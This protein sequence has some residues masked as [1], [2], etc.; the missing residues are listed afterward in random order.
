MD[1]EKTGEEFISYVDELIATSKPSSRLGRAQSSVKIKWHHNRIEAYV[2]R[3]DRLQGS[4]SLATVLSLRNRETGSHQ[5]VLDHLI[6]IE[7]G[8]STS[9]QNGDELIRALSLLHGL[10]QEQ[11]GPKLDMLQKQMDLCMEDI[12][13]IR[14]SVTV[15][16]EGEILRWLDFRQRTWRF[17]EVEEAHQ[18]TFD[19]IFRK[20]HTNTPW[21]D[22]GA[23][24]SEAGISKPY[25]INGKVGSGKSTLMKY[26]ISNRQTRVRLKEWAGQ[27]KLLSPY[28]FF[29]N[30]GTQLQKSHTGMLRS[31]LH[32]ILTQYH[33]LIPAVFP[34]LYA[35]GIPISDYEPPSYTELKGAFERLKVR[36]ASFLRICIFVDGVDEFEGDHRDMSTF[37]CS[38]ASSAIK[39]V[40]SSRPINACL[41][42]FKSC[43]T[44][45]L[46]DLTQDD[47]SIFIRD[48]L[49]THWM[50]AELRTES[51]RAVTLEAEIQEKAEGVF[52]WVRIVT[53]LLLRGLDDGDDLDDLLPKLRALPSDLRELYTRMMQ[54]MPPDYQ[55]QA[56]Q[57]FQIFEWWRLHH[58][59]DPLELLLLAFAIQQPST[60]L[61]FD[62]NAWDTQMKKRYSKR[63]KA[64]VRSRCCGLLEVRWI[65]RKSMFWPPTPIVAYL[66]RSVAEFVTS[67]DVWDELL[68]LTNN[69]MRFSPSTQIACGILS[70]L[71]SSH[72]TPDED[73]D[74]RGVEMSK[75]TNYSASILFL[76][77]S[78]YCESPDFEDSI[79]I[80]YME[81][82]DK[83][84]ASTW[85]GLALSSIVQQDHQHS[86][87]WSISLE[88]RCFRSGIDPLSNYAPLMGQA[89]IRSFAAYNGILP[90]L[91]ALDRSSK[92]TDIDALVLFA[93]HGW[94]DQKGS[95][96]GRWKTL[97]FLLRLLDDRT[98]LGVESPIGTNTLWEHAEVILYQVYR[99]P[100]PTSTV[101][102]KSWISSQNTSDDD[103]EEEE[104]EEEEKA[105]A[106]PDHRWGQD[107]NDDGQNCNN[108]NQELE[109]CNIHPESLDQKLLGLYQEEPGLYPGEL[110]LDLEDI[111]RALSVELHWIDECP[112]RDMIMV[113]EE[114]QREQER[115]SSERTKQNS[116]RNEGPNWRQGANQR[117]RFDVLPPTQ[118]QHSSSSSLFSKNIYNTSYM[119]SWLK[120]HS[121]CVD[122]LR[123]FLSNTDK[124]KE[125]LDMSIQIPDGST[126]DL[127]AMLRD[128]ITCEPRKAE[129]RG[130]YQ[131]VGLPETEQ[132]TGQYIYSLTSRKACPSHPYSSL[133]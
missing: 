113:M 132:S 58:E 75:Q 66:H 15:T 102:A 110:E 104:E 68:C 123:L 112:K 54:K 91:K 49:S 118:G 120:L 128:T 130:L 94:R 129:W 25:F 53:G 82:V 48:K 12:Q 114:E 10:I 72:P 92:L 111:E 56:S 26:I 70:I 44:L 29:W 8:N 119:P 36:S 65:R 24:L 122:I 100:D 127:Q 60:A 50:M 88:P 131:L 51:E 67:Q 71:K 43:P 61:N 98:D 46:Q 90:Y 17:E 81:T 52:L 13:K 93:L 133:D 116:M 64:R 96:L 42:V 39:V 74:L 1:C 103:K 14:S 79:L 19:W 45:R 101:H 32:S 107:S 108:G 3:L 80:G 33:D 38:I 73:K 125:L 115:V 22:F 55:V 30:V 5:E 105:A 85:Q 97:K 34:T 63:I 41:N 20:P 16:R 62:E 69:T 35:E 59:S 28:F 99:K 47:M 124:P 117:Q 18:T 11:S 31:L 57:M 126:P 40:V 83:T 37:L 89:S 9:Q 77:M 78:V 87:H 76:A 2:S 6:S 84:M 86:E 109:H 23:H 121:S 106:Q 27:I 21:H 7:A 95:F 4:L